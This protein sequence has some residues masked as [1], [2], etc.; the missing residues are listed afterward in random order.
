MRRSRSRIRSVLHR[1]PRNQGA[2]LGGS[3]PRVSPGLV[4]GIGSGR[5]DDDLPARWHTGDDVTESVPADVL[6]RAA[7]FVWGMLQ[8]IDREGE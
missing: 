1:H 5:S 8:K 6:G 7:G 2:G 3:Q 4:L